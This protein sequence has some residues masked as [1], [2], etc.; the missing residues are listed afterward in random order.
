MLFMGR[1]CPCCHWWMTSWTTG[2]YQAAS[3]KAAHLRMRR[4][5][6]AGSDRY[7]AR[8]KYVGRMYMYMYYIYINYSYIAIVLC[9]VHVHSAR[10][11][12]CAYA[13]ATFWRT[14]RMFD[15]DDAYVRVAVATVISGLCQVSG[16]GW[17]NPET[18]QV[19]HSYYYNWYALREKRGL[20]DPVS[21][22]RQWRTAF[23]PRETR[24]E[25]TGHYWR[26]C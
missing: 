15:R 18:N 6:P 11:G 17:V 16:G 19:C 10:L 9:G 23:K 7:R 13:A 8:I 5:D 2:T 1:R 26:K 22:V 24:F 20:C 21:T 4:G 3:C 12:P 14:T 25:T